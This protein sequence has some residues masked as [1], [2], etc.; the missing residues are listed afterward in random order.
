MSDFGGGNG[1]PWH[2]ASNPMPGH[3]I[4][5]A[6][7]SR[8][9]M[10][11]FEPSAG[12]TRQESSGASQF[13]DDILDWYCGTPP[14]PHHIFEGVAELVEAARVTKDAGFRTQ[15]LSTAKSLSQRA[16][17]GGEVI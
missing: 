5:A 12:A 9:L 15:L 11:Q 10:K 8:A 17:P 3:L 2:P 7:L 6:A 14:R 1:I 4:L 16:M 13:M